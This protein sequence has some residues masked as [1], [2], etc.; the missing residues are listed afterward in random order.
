MV[1]AELYNFCVEFCFFNQ[2]KYL[3]LS[4]VNP[5][6]CLLSHSDQADLHILRVEIHIDFKLVE[7][8]GFDVFGNHLAVCKLL[9][10]KLLDHY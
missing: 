9:K 3:L 6:L 1:F 5:C 2:S 4:L 10:C 8:L 7:H